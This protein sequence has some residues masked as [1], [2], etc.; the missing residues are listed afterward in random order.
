MDIHNTTGEDQDV[1]P[2]FDWDNFMHN[3]TNH[4]SH[5]VSMSW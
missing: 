5:A 4:H 1:Y 2:D 3:L